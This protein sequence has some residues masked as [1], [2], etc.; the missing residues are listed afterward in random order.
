MAKPERHDG[1]A[2]VRARGAG[3]VRRERRGRGASGRRHGERARAAGVR[4]KRRVA[5]RVMRH[6]VHA[7][8]ARVGAGG[9]A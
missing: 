9:R 4:C 5:R 3:T 8:G 1:S 6:V 7:R 2:R